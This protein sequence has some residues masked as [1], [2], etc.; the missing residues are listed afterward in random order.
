MRRT[1][2][3]LVQDKSLKSFNKGGEM[4]YLMLKKDHPGNNKKLDRGSKRNR[5]TTL[6]SDEIIQVQR[7]G[8]LSQGGN[9]GSG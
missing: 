1:L 8:G 2:D 7:D 9:S 6:R 3:F 4:M 5:E